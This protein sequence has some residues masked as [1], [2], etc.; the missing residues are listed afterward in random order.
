MFRFKALLNLILI[1]INDKKKKIKSQ[2][3]CVNFFKEIAKKLKFGD[4]IFLEGD[5]G[6]GKTFICQTIIKELTGND[7][8]SSPTFNIIQTYKYVDGI[9]IWHCDFYRIISPDEINELG[10]FDNIN[11]KIILIE[12]PK[13][14][15]NFSFNALKIK[16][17]FGKN[18]NERS[19]SFILNENWKN[20]LEI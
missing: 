16:I 10:V 20:R 17:E 14:I 8:V 11:S 19:L 6:V 15:E 18:L 7:L 2:N 12:W 13:Y 4:I 3:L 1:D 9:E 5:L